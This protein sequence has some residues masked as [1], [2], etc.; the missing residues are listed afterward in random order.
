MPVPALNTLANYRAMERERV[1]PLKS[2]ATKFF[3]F[4]TEAKTNNE[5]DKEDE[6]K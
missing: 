3:K 4:K 6:Y 5:N 1:K 2:D